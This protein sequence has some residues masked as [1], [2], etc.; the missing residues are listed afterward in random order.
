MSGVGGGWTFEKTRVPALA[1]GSLVRGAQVFVYDCGNHIEGACP[2]ELGHLISAKDED[3]WLRGY[4]ILSSLSQVPVNNVLI[5]LVFHAGGE[6]GNVEAEG[7]SAGYLSLDAYLPGPLLEYRVVV[8]PEF[9]LFTRTLGA[10][11]HQARF[12]TQ[13]G[14]MAVFHLYLAVVHVGRFDLLG[15]S[16]GPAPTAGS[17]EVTIVQDGDCRVRRAEDIP[18]PAIRIREAGR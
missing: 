18:S 3:S 10:L 1:L 12:G 8:F 6:L 9:A 11:S 5:G 13:D 17:L 16:K 15:R 2:D 4:A 7:I 14:V